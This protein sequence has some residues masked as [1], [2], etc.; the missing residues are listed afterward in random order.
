MRGFA[1]FVRMTRAADNCLHTEKSSKAESRPKNFSRTIKL[2]ETRLVRTSSCESNHTMPQ[3]VSH[4]HR[5]K[6]TGKDLF[7]TSNS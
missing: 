4:E 7:T 3:T 2:M 5:H 6:I 1:T